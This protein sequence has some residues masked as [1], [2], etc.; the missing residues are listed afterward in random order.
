HWGSRAR[1]SCGVRAANCVGNCEVLGNHE[2][3]CIRIYT[4]PM[5]FSPR[6]CS[7]SPLAVPTPVPPDRLSAPLTLRTVRRGAET[8]AW[9]ERAVRVDVDVYL[10]VCH[11]EPVVLGAE[12]Q[13]ESLR[14]ELDLGGD[15]GPAEADF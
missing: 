4:F 14:V 7:R 9:R 2:E 11:H 5:Q 10:G 13:S 15:L 8:I 3:T 12:A 6:A 1:L